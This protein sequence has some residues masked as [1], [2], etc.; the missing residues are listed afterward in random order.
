MAEYRRRTEEQQILDKITADYWTEE[1]IS[2]D[3][4][5]AEY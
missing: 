3:R 2:L 1:G 5:S 4:R